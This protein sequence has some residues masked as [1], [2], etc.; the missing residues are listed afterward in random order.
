MVNHHPTAICA[1][2]WLH[3]N[4]EKPSTKLNEPAPPNIAQKLGLIV[5]ILLIISHS[6][7]QC[8]VRGLYE[9][10]PPHGLWPCLFLFSPHLINIQL[11]LI[12]HWSCEREQEF[13]SYN[14]SLALDEQTY[15]NWW[16]AISCDNM[17]L[18][19]VRTP[20]QST[21]FSIMFTITLMPI[22]H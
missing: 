18:K 17:T 4:D 9:V 11:R 5:Y 16:G 2:K 7:G 1:G 8:H 22:C 14:Y 15:S 6:Q 10:W 12:I 19:L 20:Q 13:I 3:K 21:C